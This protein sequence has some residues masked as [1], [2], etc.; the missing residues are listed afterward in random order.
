MYKGI[1]RYDPKKKKLITQKVACNC[2]GT[3]KSG[4]TVEEDN[5]MDEKHICTM[6]GKELDYW[7][8]NANFHFQHYIGYGSAYDLHKFEAHLCCHCFDKI[9][10]TILPMFKH[11]PLSECDTSL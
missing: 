4:D 3:T 9:L 11:K 8:L 6:C 2:D 1:L 10:D 7:D 5:I